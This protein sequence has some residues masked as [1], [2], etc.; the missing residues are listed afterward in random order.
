MIKHL[1]Q[2]QCRSRIRIQI[3][4]IPAKLC[5]IL[6]S[7]EGHIFSWDTAE[8][9]DLQIAFDFIG[10]F[11]SK[12]KRQEYCQRFCIRYGIHI[13]VTSGSNASAGARLPYPQ[14]SYSSDFYLFSFSQS[15]CLIK[16]LVH[17]LISPSFLCADLSIISHKFPWV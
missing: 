17:A 1:P 6:L 9:V 11:L 2:I 16:L 15:L 3:Q 5:L 4:S 8:G 7:Y 14:P 10:F 12:I 13:S